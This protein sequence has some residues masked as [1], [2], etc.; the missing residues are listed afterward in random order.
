MRKIIL[1]II[2][3][4][5]S[6]SLLSCKKEPDYQFAKINFSGYFDTYG[7]VVV[8]YNGKTT[9][10]STVESKLLPAIKKFLQS[11]EQL[12]AG[13]LSNVDSQVKTINKNAGLLKNE[14]PVKTKVSKELIDLLKISNEISKKVSTFDVTIG[15]LTS[16]WNIN[17][18]IEYCQIND[19][20]KCGVPNDVDISNA[21]NTVDYESIVIDEEE[22]T[23][24]LKNEGT[25]I[26]LG[27]IAK[28]YACDKLGE[29]IKSKG[30]DFYIINF[31]GS[32][33]IEGDSFIYKETNTR[34][35][36]SIENPS[37][38]STTVLDIYDVKGSFVTSSNSYRSITIGDKTYTHI[39][40]PKTGYPVDNELDSV[41]I[42]CE[43]NV[44]ADAYSTACFTVGAEEAINLILNAGYNGV[45]VTKNKEIIIVGNLEYKLL[46]S[47]YK[48]I[49][50]K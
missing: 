44:Y 37:N 4:F 14:E 10:Y 16:L 3:F 20:S 19:N 8:E 26:D 12:F 31:G 41:T 28:G 29:L 2:L 46:D 5:I 18:L 42:I 35:K 11:E 25:K 15:A 33:K 17:S 13:E 40:N 27:A 39:I 24:Y 21:K 36:V 49:N 23:V 50:R 1:F 22:S 34:M 38:P 43:D 48:I 32:V 9:S 47:N 45:L 7:Y 6:I 30:Y